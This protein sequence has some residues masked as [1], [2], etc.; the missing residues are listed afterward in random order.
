LLWL[1]NLIDGM[2]RWENPNRAK[3]QLDCGKRKRFL[4][5]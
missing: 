3:Y 4:K 1:V 5:K 2:P